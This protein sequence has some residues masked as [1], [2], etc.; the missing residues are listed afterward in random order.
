MTLAN[1][2]TLLRIFLVPVF[3]GF[4]LSPIL[5][6]RLWA[7]LI[8]FTAAITDILDGWVARR[9]GR[10]SN[11]GKVF[12]PIADKLI[13]L[14]ALIPMV[15]E[16]VMPVLIAI[17]LIGREL[18][19]G[20]LRIVA[21]STAGHVIAAS[22]LGKAKTISQD[23]AIILILTRE[24]ILDRIMAFPI[25]T[26]ALYVALLFTVWSMVDYFMKNKAAL[27]GR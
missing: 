17:V 21:V 20:G 26:V 15:A 18:L 22:W 6:G 23:T 14:A 8:F 13:V 19:I 10:V 4:L 2:I 16:G 27:A 1:K 3:L 9:Q 24:D 7:A 25:E 11:F 12:D 5:Y